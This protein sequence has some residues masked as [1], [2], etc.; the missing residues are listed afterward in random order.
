VNEP[1]SETLR[2]STRKDRQGA[3]LG[4]HAASGSSEGLQPL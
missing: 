3:G 1:E 2:E 4:R